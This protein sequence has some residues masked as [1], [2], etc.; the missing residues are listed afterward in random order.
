MK[1][2]HEKLTL[3]LKK[4]FSNSDFPKFNY[5]FLFLIFWLALVAVV[6]FPMLSSPL[7]VNAPSPYTIK[8]PRDIKY[9]DIRKT[10]ALRREARQAVKPVYRYSALALNR[11][12]QDIKNFFYLLK[13]V[14]LQSL[15]K[16]KKVDYLQAE[17]GDFLNRN[18]LKD[19]V[20]LKEERIPYL[21]KKSLQIADSILAGRV[22]EGELYKKRED[23]RRLTLELNLSSLEKRVVEAVILTFLRPNYVYD[24]AETERLRSQAVSTVEPYEVQKLKGEVI[25]REGEIITEQKSEL[26]KKLGVWGKK[27]DYRT[28]VANVI[29]VGSYLALLFMFIYF[30][31]PQYF[32]LKYLTLVCLLVLSEVFLTALIVPKFSPFLVPVVSLPMLIV[33]LLDAEVAILSLAVTLLICSLIGGVE[34]RFILSSFV[35]G[36]LGVFLL[37]EVRRQADLIRGGLLVALSSFLLSFFSSSIY[38]GSIQDVLMEGLAGL[39]GGFLAA[40]LTIGALPILENLFHLTTNLRLVEISNPHHPLLEELIVKAPGTY[41]HSVMVSNLAERAAR[42][43]KANPILT[44][45]GAQFHDIGKIK[46][47]LF[48]VENQTGKNPHDRTNPTLSFLVITSHVKEGVELSNQCRLPQE[49][50]N[51]IEEHHGTSVLNY[52]YNRAVEKGLSPRVTKDNF[53]YPGRK[54]QTKEAAIVMLADSVEAA[55]RTLRKPTSSRIE[56]LIN[57]IIK[58]KLEDGQLDESNLTL[59]DLNKIA[60]SFKEVLISVYHSRIDYPGLAGN[61]EENA[62]GRAKKSSKKSS[63]K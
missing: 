4:F 34:I 23:I 19:A 61:E 48:F 60:Q 32:E 38:F 21:E 40:V 8:S 52:F 50:K 14:H 24:A 18:I 35:A 42:A 43:V 41:N 49:L 29:L 37:R 62:K 12:T 33:I 44:R 2:N 36:S 45:V 7:R 13:K 31:R 1:L 16:E 55:S 47:P 22:L 3:P 51:I 20:R 9:I 6:A 58:E 11:T 39:G 57:K 25:V 10:E 28:L 30:F 15:S 17:F 54:P 46:R 26:L 27:F 56:E 59:G 5:L 63:L 53:R